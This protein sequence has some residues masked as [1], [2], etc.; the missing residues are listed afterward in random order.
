MAHSYSHLYQLPT[1]GLR[2]FTCMALGDVR[3]WRLYFAQAILEGHPIKLFNSG[4]MRRS[5]T[6]V[7]DVVEPIFRFVESS[8]RW[9]F[10]LG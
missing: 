7:D 4:N 1:T 5:F 3:I 9:R 2:F 10:S 6:F 8:A